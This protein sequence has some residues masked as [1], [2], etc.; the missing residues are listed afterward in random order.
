MRRFHIYRCDPDSD[1]R[2]RMQTLEVDPGPEVR[3]LLDALNALNAIDPSLSFRRS[4]REGVCGS[5]AM[6]INGR[7]G[8]ACLTSLRAL[9]D[10]VVLKPLPGLPMIRELIVDM[11]AFF[12]Q[13]HSIKP[14]LV[15]DD[16]PPEKE[17][18]LAEPRQVR[19]SCRAASGVSIPR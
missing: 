12:E 4:C 13:Y 1:A 14:Y 2:P 19:R 11:T 18:L 16:P 3:M 6:N 15:N 7:N 9:P 10:T 17:Q 8:L 5:D